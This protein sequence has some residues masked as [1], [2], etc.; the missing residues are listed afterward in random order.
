MR[1]YF[2]G[3]TVLGAGIAF[4]VWLAAVPS[5]TI[6]GIFQAI[7]PQA[8]PTANKRG[9]A[10]VFQ[11]ANNNS[12][13]SAG[14]T[15]CDDGSGN[16][17]ESGCN[18]GG[19]TVNSGT[20]HQTAFYAA[21]GSTISGAGPGT[22]GFVWTSN[23]ASADPTFQAVPTNIPSVTVSTS[24]PVTV[25]SS[26][27][28]FNNAAGAL[29]YNLPTITSGTVGSQYCFRNSVTKTGAIT[30]QLPASTFMDLN[31]ANGSSAGTFVSTGALGDSACVVA[32]TT[33]QYAAYVGG[34][35]WTNN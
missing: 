18:S 34:G 3:W 35:V 14:A 19:G 31:G 27:Y 8:V 1:K 26:G 24:G 32:V 11:L 28:Y 13:G 15:I 5:S 10:T 33:T 25:S 21:T 12:A 7:I 9:N 23:G 22:T 16:A 17:T 4:V 2:N 29:T 6:A 20:A 30:L